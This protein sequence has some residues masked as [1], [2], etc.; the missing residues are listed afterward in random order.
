MIQAGSGI[1]A[2]FGLVN[3]EPGYAP[4]VICDKLCGQAMAWSILTALLHRERGGGG[5][6]IEVPMLETSIEFTMMDHMVGSTFEPPL[7]PTGY[8]RLLTRHR[9][10]F[11]T[12]D[13]YLCV[14]PYSDRN[15]RDLFEFLGRPDLRDDKRFHG[16]G[17]RV[18]HADFLYG[19]IAAAA[20]G[21]TSAEWAG[22][23]D[24][25]SIACM[26]VC[27]LDDVRDD[28]HVRDVGLFN[29]EQHPSEGAYQAVRS[30]VWFSGAPFAIRRHA[31]RLGE[32]TADVLAKAGLSGEEIAAASG[33]TAAPD[34][35]AA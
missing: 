27:G 4:T 8:A 18:D 7:A 23:C 5:Q 32:H 16:V 1:A 11:A 34:G 25:V 29:I 12:K 22:F 21:H 6:A 19:T 30:P 2:L 14:L 17:G 20:P 28:P 33:M 24:R 26:P 10:P 3:G 35:D 13:G 31:P 15:W 9:R